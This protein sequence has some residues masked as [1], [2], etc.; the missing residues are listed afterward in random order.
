M[1]QHHTPLHATRH[2]AEGPRPL[3]RDQF[4]SPSETKLAARRAQSL[5]QYGFSEWGG[6]ADVGDPR[7][8]PRFSPG[9]RTRASRRCAPAPGCEAYKTDCGVR[10]CE[11]MRAGDGQTAA[12]MDQKCTVE[13]Q[14]AENATGAARTCVL[15]SR[16]EWT[17]PSG[18]V[19]VSLRTKTQNV[20]I[21][22]A[23]GVVHARPWLT[24]RRESR[25]REKSANRKTEKRSGHTD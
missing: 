17:S 14:R 23:S 12:G 13:T 21:D 16:I 5:R 7:G 25:A 15:S 11:T 4:H 24:R 2:C 1:S 20:V 3:R 10:A 8:D 9:W 19:R 6:R 18:R 22:G